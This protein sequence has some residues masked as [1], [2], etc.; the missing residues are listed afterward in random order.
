METIIQLPKITHSRQRCNTVKYRIAVGAR[1][2]DRSIIKRETINGVT[3]RLNSNLEYQPLYNKNLKQDVSPKITKPEIYKALITSINETQN[4]L[5]ATEA[6]IQI[7]NDRTSPSKRAIIKFRGLL[8]S[9][10]PKAKPALY[11]F[12]LSGGN[13]S[14]LVRRIIELRESFTCVETSSNNENSLKL[15]LN[16]GVQVNLYWDSFKQKSRIMKL[17]KEVD[18]RQIKNVAYNHF[19][20]NYEITQKYYL[21]KNLLS[22]YGDKIHKFV[23][24]TFTLN[25]ESKR[26]LEQLSHFLVQ[27]SKIYLRDSYSDINLPEVVDSSSE[28]DIFSKKQIFKLNT[29]SLSPKARYFEESIL[30][31]ENLLFTTLYKDIEITKKSRYSIYNMYL[32]NI[33]STSVILLPSL[34]ENKNMWLIKP[35]DLN[36][37]NRVEVFSAIDQ[38]YELL[39]KYL[40]GVPINTFGQSSKNEDDGNS[41]KKPVNVYKPQKFVIQK[42]IEKHLLINQRKFDIRIYGLID[43]NNSI[44]ISKEGYIRTSTDTFTLDENSHFIHLTNNAVQKHSDNY[45]KFEDSNIISSSSLKVNLSDIIQ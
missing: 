40:E 6:K 16:S 45:C 35:D 34:D 36:R 33:T 5:N 22:R 8:P 42:Y 23:P 1:S 28:T 7:S 24:L 13:N 3:T 25:F 37:G 43:Q 41:Y 30:K 21:Y 12:M 27:F 39:K 10:F 26:F 18:S 14:R 19:E 15:S 32:L 17:N 38:L 44:F 31:I 29:R 2:F 20:S 9:I 4:E 11:G